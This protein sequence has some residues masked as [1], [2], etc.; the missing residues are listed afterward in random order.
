M[1]LLL[2]GNEPNNLPSTALPPN[3]KDEALSYSHDPICVLRCSIDFDRVFDSMT[4]NKT[5]GN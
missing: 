2:S 4:E 5:I 3:L 1:H